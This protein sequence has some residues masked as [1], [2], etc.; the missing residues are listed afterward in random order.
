MKE[1]IS[2]KAIWN[3]AGISGAAL[4][5]ISTAFMFITQAMGTSVTGFW[6][7]A[8]SSVMWAAKFGGCIW[9]MMFF[10]K[11]LCREFDN[12]TGAETF[13]FGMATALLSALIYS[14][15]YLANV[16]FIF[17]DIIEETFNTVLLSSAGMLDSNSMAMME[18]MQENFPQT[19]F[20]SN[21]I[22]CFLYGTLLSSILSRIIP[23]RDPF[24][25]YDSGNH[26]DQE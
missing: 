8:L 5:L 1:E 17:P 22:Y 3:K 20:F 16:T 7:L 13:K 19:A 15:A 2:T 14:A 24:A 11:R 21:L 26:K 25:G 9:L 12:V 4:G 10:M 6:A 23:S 18:K